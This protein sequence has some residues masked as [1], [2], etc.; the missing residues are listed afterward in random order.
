MHPLSYQNVKKKKPKNL[1]KGYLKTCKS[2]KRPYICTRNQGNVHR[3][4]DK[5][6][7]QKKIC[8]VRKKDSIFAVPNSRRLLGGK[9][10]RSFRKRQRKKIKKIFQ[11]PCQIKKKL[12]ICTRLQKQRHDVS[13][14]TRR[15]VHRH[16]ELTA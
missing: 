8:R 1:K 9:A 7:K 5:K 11:N 16:I 2:K 10:K 4:K 15:H 14:K 13:E 3:Q 12:Y 6:K